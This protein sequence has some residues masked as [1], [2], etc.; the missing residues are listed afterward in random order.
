[1]CDEKDFFSVNWNWFEFRVR[2]GWQMKVAQ[3]WK[4]RMFQLK[5]NG[6][7]HWLPSC[8]MHVLVVVVKTAIWSASNQAMH[9]TALP[10]LRYRCIFW[11][12]CWYQRAKQ[13]NR[14]YIL[15]KRCFVDRREFCCFQ[16][17]KMH[18]KLNFAGRYFHN[19]VT[20]GVN[21][22]TAAFGAFDM[23]AIRPRSIHS[24]HWRRN[25]DMSAFCQT[26]PP[27]DLFA[28]RKHLIAFE[29]SSRINIK[30]TRKHVATQSVY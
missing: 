30:I 6:F 5:W 4:A 29:M 17:N 1:M 16:H 22:L 7:H 14:I 13:C 18:N 10:P 28:F 8:L 23:H 12:V 20:I 21:R 11:T 3:K 26:N 2:L 25:R 27:I 9:S 24:L 19:K 15:A